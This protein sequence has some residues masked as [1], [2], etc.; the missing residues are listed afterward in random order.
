MLSPPGKTITGRHHKFEFCEVEGPLDVETYT[1]L[2]NSFPDRSLFEAMKFVGDKLSF[3]ESSRDFMPWIASSQPWSSFY[4]FIKGEG[5]V[6]WCNEILRSLDLDGAKPARFE[7]SILKAETGFMRPHPDTAKKR[8]TCVFYFPASPT[9]WPA[10]YGGDLEM[11]RH[12][13]APLDDYTGEHPEWDELETLL[14]AP[15]RPNA[16]VLFSRCGY[17]LHGVRG[18]AGPRDRRSVTINL[19]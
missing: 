10:Q 16:A 6:E 18:V 3:N 15:Y 14:R 8:M 17:S 13:A 11:L 9:Y 1:A 2:A 19:I 5:F 4:E 12:K 7:F